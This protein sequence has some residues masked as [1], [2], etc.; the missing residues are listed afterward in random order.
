MVDRLAGKNTL[1]ALSQNLTPL[2]VNYQNLAKPPKH[3]QS[4]LWRFSTTYKEYIQYPVESTYNTL[5][6]AS[7]WKNVSEIQFMP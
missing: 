3:P 1:T 7:L 2:L 4:L 5:M 6:N